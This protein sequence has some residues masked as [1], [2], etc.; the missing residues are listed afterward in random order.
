MRKVIAIGESILDTVFKDDKPES[1]FVGGRVANAAASAA[2]AA[3]DHMRNWFLGSNGDWVTMG[4]PSDGSYGIPEGIV[5]G[6][7]CICDGKGNYEIVQ[8]LNFDAF[9]QEKLDK[10]VGELVAE[11]QA[12]QSL[13]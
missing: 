12:V 4:V 10:T 9:S 5:C 11:A 13:L 7:P 6:M 8:G 3:I 1:T 2:S